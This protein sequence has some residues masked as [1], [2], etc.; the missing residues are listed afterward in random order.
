MCGG[1]WKRRVL[2]SMGRGKISITLSSWR[3]WTPLRPRKVSLATRQ[4]KKI[5]MICTN[6]PHLRFQINIRITTINNI[7][8]HQPSTSVNNLSTTISIY[9]VWSLRM[10]GLQDVQS[11]PTS[12][13]YILT[14]LITGGELHGDLGWWSGFCQRFSAHFL[15]LWNSWCFVF[16]EWCWML[17]TYWCSCN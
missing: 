2:C 4:T 8:D 10:L 16:A 5:A 13:V 11:Q 6:V 7:N 17:R 12:E 1:T 9:F 14:E 3:R 15:K